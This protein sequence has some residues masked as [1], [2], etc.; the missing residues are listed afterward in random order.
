LPILKI[1]FVI[2]FTLMQIDKNLVLDKFGKR[3]KSLRVNNNFT[4]AELA[5]QL[6]VEISQ[7][8]RI[9]RGLINTSVIMI[10][11]TAEVLNI[12]PSEFF[13]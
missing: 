8:S 13:K 11:K 9:E 5:L 2:N 7:I 10:Y 1:L 12:P 6:N 4:Q 3:Y